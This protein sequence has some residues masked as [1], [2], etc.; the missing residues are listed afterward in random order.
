MNPI[1]KF[2]ANSASTGG[3]GPLFENKVQSSFVLLMIAGGYAPCLPTWP[4]HKVKL[5]G[6]YQ[7]FETDDFIVYT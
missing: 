6:R 4:I 7:G 5:Q 2:V 1:E 3:L